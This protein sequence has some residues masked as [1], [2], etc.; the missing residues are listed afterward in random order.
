M[1]FVGCPT[2]DKP[3]VMPGFQLCFGFILGCK[4]T[5]NDVRL[6]VFSSRWLN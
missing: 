4:G 5:A 1:F 6:A 2:N 3:V